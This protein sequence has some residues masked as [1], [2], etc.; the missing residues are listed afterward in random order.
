MNFWESVKISLRALISNKLRSILTMLGIIIGVGAVIAMVGIGNGATSDITSSIQGLGANLLTVSP[1]QSSSNGVRSAAGSMNSLKMSDAEEIAAL[2]DSIKAVAPTNNK[3][4]VQVVL[5]AENTNTTITGATETYT[6][7]R[8]LEISTG[9]FIT[10]EDVQDYAKVAVVG[11][12]VV[13]SLL[14]SEDADIVGQKIKINNI[15]FKVVGVTVS[16]GSSGMNSSDDMIFI[17]IT[18]NASRLVGNKYLRTIY[19]AA[20]SEEMMDQAEA[21]IIAVLEKAHGI[22]TG[23]GES[24]DFTVQNQETIL[25]TVQ[26]VSKTMSML[27]GGIA[28]ISLLVGGIGIM[29]I[30]LVSVTERTREIGIRKAIGAKEKDIMLQ[31]LTEAVVLC[32]LGGMIGIGFGYAASALVSKFLSMGSSISVSSI[33]I[34]FCFSALIGVVFGVV[35]ARK[36]AKMDPI[37]ALRF[38]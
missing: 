8:N 32:L 22:D 21:E 29:N 28:G 3:S 30:M 34:A 27:L 31:F 5:G 20:A 38:E 9:R 23:A 7:V 11:P 4:G 33:I 24:D 26:S 14:G 12:S 2:G 19:V 36:A 13:S 6:E 17:P 35:P 37:D 15:P 10:A 1:G 16:Q 25:E 18:T